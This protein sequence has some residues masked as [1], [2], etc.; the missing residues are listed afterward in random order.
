MDMVL[1]N[2]Y[3]WK[4]LKVCFCTKQCDIQK[5]YLYVLVYLQF[6]SRAS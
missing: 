1:E 4:D 3:L 2:A 6:T 5:L